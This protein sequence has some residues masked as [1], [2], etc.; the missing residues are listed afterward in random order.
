MKTIVIS[1]VHASNPNAPYSWFVPQAAQA[2]IKTLNAVAAEPQV[3]NL[4]LLGDILDLWLYP[5]D[6]IPWT[7][8]QITAANPDLFAALRNC[9]QRV[10]NVYYA[11]GNHDMTLTLADLPPGIK[12]LPDGGIYPGWHCEHGNSVDMFNAPDNTGDRTIGGYSLGYFITRIAASAPN[13]QELRAELADSLSS[14][15]R[16]EGADLVRLVIVL[17]AASS[18]IPVTTRLRFAE[19]ELDMKYTIQDIYEGNYYAQLVPTWQARWG[20]DYRYTL[21]TGLAK[22]GLDWYARKLLTGSNPPKLVV[23]GHTHFAELE[24]RSRYANSGCGCKWEQ[25]NMTKNPAI[26]Y[27]ELANEIPAIKLTQY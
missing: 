4:V 7:P 2:T 13:R 19:P 16:T 21:L 27:I 8:A 14:P 26:T 9:V 25:S 24:E 6:Q 3:T 17:A 12:P 18:N 11:N 23:F 20:K 10:P 22:G 5:A 15:S 1:D